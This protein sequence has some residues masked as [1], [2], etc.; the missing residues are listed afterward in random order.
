MNNIFLDNYTVDTSNN[1]ET[2]D[3]LTTKTIQ[4]LLHKLPIPFGLSNTSHNWYILRYFNIDALSRLNLHWYYIDKL[5]SILNWD[6]MSS[7]ELPGP[8]IVKHKD[9]INWP[10]FLT[11]GK[12][13]EINYLIHVIDILRKHSNIFF[14]VRHKKLYYNKQFMLVFPE[15]VDWQWCAKHLKLS[16]YILMKY[17]DKFNIRIISKYQILSHNIATSK[18]DSICWNLAA[19]NP[20]SENIIH[21]VR[22]RINWTIVCK[23]QK[24]S[25]AFMEEHK[26]FLNWDM[27]SQYQ[28]MSIEFIKNNISFLNLNKLSKNKN[29]NKKNTIN[30]VNSDD[31]WF[32]VEPP[33]IGNYKK[34]TFLTADTCI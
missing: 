33:V 2:N 1:T 13:K 7:K 5:A 20:L 25:D 15:F 32:I 4:I 31:K 6:I 17:W 8:I 24:L 18:K 27:V 19:K 16:T 10:I 11:N 26:L 21:D 23:K 28:N 22:Y 30:I 14:D 12:P 29:Y 34:V 9:K 3:I